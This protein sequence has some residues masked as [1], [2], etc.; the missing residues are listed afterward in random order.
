MEVTV[1]FLDSYYKSLNLVSK[2]S[3]EEIIKGKMAMCDDSRVYQEKLNLV[4]K[5]WPPPQAGW[6]ALSV[7]GSFSSMDARVAV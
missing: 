1:Q 7:D 4:P 5:L 6:V 3:M 2:Y